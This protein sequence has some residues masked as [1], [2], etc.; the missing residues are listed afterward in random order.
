MKI[1]Q[2]VIGCISIVGLTI[3]LAA[4]GQPNTSNSDNKDDKTLSDVLNGKEKRKIVMTERKGN[5]GDAEVRWAGYIGNGKVKIHPYTNM[6]GRF[7]WDDID[8][9]SNSK[10]KDI[11][12]KQDKNYEK[13]GS[14]KKLKIKEE[15]AKITILTDDNKKAALTGLDFNAKGNKEDKFD[16]LDRGFGQ[17]VEQHPDNWL[18]MK[19]DDE[20][21]TILHVESKNGEKNLTNENIKKAKDKYDNINVI[22]RN[23]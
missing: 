18:E 13:L 21:E 23:K 4:C 15:S 8:E 6:E 17:T 11:L 22:E 10:F 14:N 12:K 20:N 16:Q 5:T 2:K 7:D 3:S 19:S 1:R 9:V